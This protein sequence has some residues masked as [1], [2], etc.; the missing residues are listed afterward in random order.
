[1]LTEK[2]KN[3]PFYM[4]DR[5]EFK[6]LAIRYVGGEII[7]LERDLFGYNDEFNTFIIAKKSYNLGGNDYKIS[8]SHIDEKKNTE[9][10]LVIA[11]S[12]S[13]KF[14]QLVEEDADLRVIPV[15]VENLFKNDYESA[16][17]TIIEEINKPGPGSLRNYLKI[18]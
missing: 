17:P 10:I 12:F 5:T 1:M 6:K 16:L 3:N 8:L 4:M 15:T 11:L 13:K 9:H 2:Q 18:L 7:N 14:I